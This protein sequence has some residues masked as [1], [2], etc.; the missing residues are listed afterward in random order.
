MILAMVIFTGLA[1]GIPKAPSYGAASTSS[2]AALRGTPPGIARLRAEPL[3]VLNSLST[4][5]A[6]DGPLLRTGMVRDL[7]KPLRVVQPLTAASA[8]SIRGAEWQWGGAVRVV[9]AE[10]LR[11]KL[12]D[13]YAVDTFWVYGESDSP[14]AFNSSL[15]DENGTIWTPSVNGEII[16]FEIAAPARAR[17]TVSLA[18]IAEIHLPQIPLDTSC[19]RDFWCAAPTD[20]RWA[21]SAIA[22]YTVIKKDGSV[23]SCT[24]GLLTD[25]QETHTPYF[26]TANHCVETASEAASVEL[27]WDFRSY[28]CAGGSPPLNASPR[29]HGSTLLIASAAYDTTLLK[30]NSVPGQRAWFGWDPRSSALTS[31]LILHRISHPLGLQQHYSSSSLDT[32]SSTCTGIGRPSY[33]YSTMFVGATAAGSS[34]APVFYGDGYVVGQLRGDCGPNPSDN[35]DI[36][37][38]AVDGS[39]G[40]AYPLLERYLENETTCTAGS[41]MLCLNSG[42]FAVTVTWRTSSSSGSGQAVPMTNDTGHFWFFGASNVELVIKILDGRGVNGKF[43]VFYGALSDVEYTINVRDVSTGVSKSYFNPVGRLASVSDVNAF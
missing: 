28:S 1:A 17:V 14:V 2:V 5:R 15:A 40:Q 37:N 12:T 38:R 4:V 20:V 26:L 11:L 34:G 30:L 22:E 31:G 19:I 32:T 41:T 9:G 16:Y 35:C 29:S 7:P 43:W 36:R 10:R 6:N 24:G 18:S 13:V 42:R 3:A 27:Y 8:V 23:G 25:R 21:S 39:F 33:I